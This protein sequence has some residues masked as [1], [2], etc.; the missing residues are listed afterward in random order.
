MDFW[1]RK[2][3]MEWQGPTLRISPAIG[4]NRGASG[5]PGTNYLR[6]LVE[7][8]SGRGQAQA[9]TLDPQQQAIEQLLQ[10]QQA[11]QGPEGYAQPVPDPTQ[12]PIPQ[13]FI[14]NILRGDR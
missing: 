7:A 12:G 2:K 4:A 11:P 8:M 5:T 14:E 3:A 10:Q 9:G 13:D 1:A 6:E